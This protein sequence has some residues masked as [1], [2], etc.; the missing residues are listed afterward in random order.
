MIK[1]VH[2]GCS[3]SEALYSC[4]NYAKVQ[5]QNCLNFYVISS[6]VQNQNCLNF[7]VISSDMVL[8]PIF[9]L[10]WRI[11]LNPGFKNNVL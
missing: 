10:V 3:F 11:D 2:T 4:I 1:I 8:P 9:N 5:N 7:Y 6:E